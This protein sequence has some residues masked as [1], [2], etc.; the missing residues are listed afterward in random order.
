MKKIALILALLSLTG[1]VEKN[2]VG[3]FCS[4]EYGLSC[5]T[6]LQQLQ[7]NHPDVT[8][9]KTITNKCND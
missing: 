3:C 2:E 9:T 5:V 6:T 7:E 4:E 1:C 8:F